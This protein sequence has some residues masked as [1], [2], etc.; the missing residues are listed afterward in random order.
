MGTSCLIHANQ[1]EN[2]IDDFQFPRK[3]SDKLV[4]ITFDDGPSIYSTQLMNVLDTYQVPAIFFV[5]G[6]NFEIIPNGPESVKEM[7]ERGHY[8]GLHSMTHNMDKLYFAR[9]APQN[10]VSE[11]TQVKELVYDATGGFESQLCRAPYGSKKYFKKG[12]YSAVE[13]VG[14]TCIDWNVDSLD[15][16]GISADQIVSNVK[17]DYKRSEYPKEV[18]LLF[19][20]KKETVKAL[21]RIIEYFQEL[22][23]EFGG[24]NPTKEIHLSK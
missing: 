15:W 3:E 23:Y 19:H 8:V 11:M 16:S 22:G 20:E 6:E 14:L 17:S 10:F 12:H 1:V 7:I 24:Y 4:Y 21:P 18:V 13:N 2:Q 5:I 9:N